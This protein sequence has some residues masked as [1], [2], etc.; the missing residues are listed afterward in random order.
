[1]QYVYNVKIKVSNEIIKLCSRLLNRTVDLLWYG[2][3]TY[4][5][6]E[7][8]PVGC[9][10]LTHWPYFLVLHLPVVGGGG[11]QGVLVSR[12]CWCPRGWC[13]G[14]VQGVDISSHPW[15]GPPPPTRT[16]TPLLWPCDV[17][18]DAFGVT[19][20]PP[21]WT[22]WV[23]HACENITFIRFATRVVNI[24]IYYR[25]TLKLTFVVR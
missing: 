17:S 6:Q 14:A 5:K 16:S 1:M 9:V 23:T 24:Y 19:P 7:C 10:L 2:K 11:V 21:Y 3:N 4:K 20:P 12:G 13:P 18:H 15:S 8:I 25:F 22:Q